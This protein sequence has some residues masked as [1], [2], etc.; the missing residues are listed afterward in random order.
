MWF[1]RTVRSGLTGSGRPRFHGWESLMAAAREQAVR[2][3]RPDAEEAPGQAKREA[4]RP[5]VN[6]AVQHKAADP[7]PADPKPDVTPEAPV[8]LP[9]AA[10]AAAPGQGQPK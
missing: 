4:A 5:Q 8:E 10:P 6:D 9:P 2:A 7:K 3:R 1:D